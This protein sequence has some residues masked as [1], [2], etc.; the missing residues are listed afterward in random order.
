MYCEK[1]GENIVKVLMVL[2]MILEILIVI[3]VFKRS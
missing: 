2:V 1:I 3:E